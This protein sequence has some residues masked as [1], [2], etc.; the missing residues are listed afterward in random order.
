[1]DPYT[2]SKLQL[3]KK[4]LFSSNF[5]TEMY[6]LKFQVSP[7]MH[8]KLKLKQ[9]RGKNVKSNAFYKKHHRVIAVFEYL[10]EHLLRY[11]PRGHACKM[12]CKLLQH[13]MRR[14]LNDLLKKWNQQNIE[15]SWMQSLIISHR[16]TVSML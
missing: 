10:S 8:L 14:F 15:K 7:L 1:M 4:W 3:I 11:K 9:Q 12:S 5:Y 16:H 13:F 2:N 6:W